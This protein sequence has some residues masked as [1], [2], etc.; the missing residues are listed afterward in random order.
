MNF[1][2]SDEQL[3][4]AELAKQIMSDKATQERM[5]ELEKSEGPRF[6]PDLWREVA[7]SGVL[8]IAVPEEF[9]GAGMG[10]LNCR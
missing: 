4:I 8:G 5:T 6:D 7:K 3:A 10:F 9:G 2:C 1:S